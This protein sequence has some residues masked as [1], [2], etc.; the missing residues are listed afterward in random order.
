[1]HIHIIMITNAI[2]LII[3]RT[4]NTFIPSQ[5]MENLKIS[6]SSNNHLYITSNVLSGIIMNIKSINANAAQ[7]ES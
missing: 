4:D 7:H 5:V 6:I 2:Q 1:M 3:I